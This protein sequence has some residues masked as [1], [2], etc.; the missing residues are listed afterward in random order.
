MNSS[1]GALLMLLLAVFLLLEYFTGR[2]DWLFALGKD[3]SA[4]YHAPAPATGTAT[5]PPAAQ[6]GA[7][8]YNAARRN[9]AVAYG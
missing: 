3:V 4:G 2:L 5:P 7:P 8:G 9:P 1:P 6:P